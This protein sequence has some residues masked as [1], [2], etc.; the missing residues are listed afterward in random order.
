MSISIW[1]TL[2]PKVKPS[3]EIQ[4]VVATLALDHTIDLDL[5][6]RMFPFAEYRPMQF[7]GLVF[8]L[9]KPK[10]ATLIFGSGK[11]VCTGARSE[12]QVAKA[13]NRVISEL[14][15]N[16]IVITSKPKKVKIQNI[17]ASGNLY[18]KIDLG[19][20][21]YKLRKTIYEPEQFPG[22]IYRMD[23]PKV[24]FLLF[25]SGKIVCVGA[26]KEEEVYQAVNNLYKKLE[27]EKI[28]SYDS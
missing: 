22:L 24:V 20:V 1:R 11:M 19:E 17:V 23:N 7:P 14:K 4:N 27:D 10:T 28:I 15:N 25:A 12:S 16:G 8:R 2:L 18:G 5:M 13:L 9:K 6:T 21:V 26:K 3:I